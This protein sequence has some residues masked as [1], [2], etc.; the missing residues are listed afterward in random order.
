LDFILCLFFVFFLVLSATLAALLVFLTLLLCHFFLRRLLAP[1]RVSCFAP[2]MLRIKY[3][4][5]GAYPKKLRTNLGVI[6]CTIDSHFIRFGREAEAGLTW[7]DFDVR[8]SF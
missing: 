4:A 6:L 1:F 5:T 2:L 8:A 7:H 3:R